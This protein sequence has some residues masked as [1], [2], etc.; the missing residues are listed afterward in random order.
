MSF[1][2]DTEA[3]IHREFETREE[4][5]RFCEENGFGDWIIEDTRPV[6]TVE[7][8]RPTYGPPIWNQM[9]AM[10]AMLRA[11]YAPALR[12]AIFNSVNVITT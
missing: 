2:V 12:D 4:A 7:D 3:W 6:Y 5:A 8:C 9:E 1:V 10:D 11:T